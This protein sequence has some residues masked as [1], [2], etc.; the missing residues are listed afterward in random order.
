M[1]STSAVYQNPSRVW[2]VL[3]FLFSVPALSPLF[4]IFPTRSA[5]GLLHLYRLVQLD[6]LWRNGVFFSRWLPDLA[7]GYGLPL[8]NYYAPL[9]YYLTTPF[10]LTGIPFSLALNLSLAASMLGSAMGMFCLTRT[11]LRE[12]PTLEAHTALAA[13]T[14]AIAFL[15][16]PYLLFNPLQ[17]GNLA[18]QWA[19]AFAPFALWRFL[20]LTQKPN[21]LNWVAAAIAFAAV[22]LS[23]NVTSFLFAPLLFVFVLVSVYSNA[24]PSSPPPARAN[25]A[26]ELLRSPVVSISALLLALGLSAFFWLPALLERDLVQIERVIVTPDFDYR[27]NFVPIAELVSFLPHA[28]TGRL[29]PA[30]PSTPGVIQ[31]ALG[32]IGLALLVTRCRVRRALPLFFLAAAALCFTGLML[33]FSQPLWESVSILS[34]VQLPMR[35]RGMVALCLAPIA[36]TAVLV[37]APRW[38]VVGAGIAVTAMIVTAMPVLYPRYAHD[39][40]L[41]PT[42]AEMFAYEHKS[43]VIGTTSFGEYLPVWVQN[44]PDASP[45]EQA[46]AQNRLPDRLVLPEGVISCGGEMH[47]TTQIACVES[48]DSWHALYRGF[49]FPGW[50]AFADQQPVEIEPTPRTGLITFNV[51]KSGQIKVTY[52]GTGIEHV[53]DWIS[54]ASSLIVLGILAFAVVRRA[55]LVCASSI[56]PTE[57]NHSPDS[58]LKI[59]F[60]LFLLALSLLAV[61]FL[62]AD[63]MSNPF[64]AHFDGTQVEGISQPRNV[65]FGNELLLLG[66]DQNA[67]NLRPGEILSTTLYWRALPGLKTN[68]STFVHLTAP[69]GFVL[70]QKDNLHPANL[71]TTQ[72]DLQA[73]AADE[74]S[75][76][77]PSTLAPGEYELRV[78]VYDPRTNTRLDL[79]EG[80]DHFLLGKITVTK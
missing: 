37:L 66:Y 40:P 4:S 27:F 41:S 60:P 55:Q 26:R 52:I 13:F 70:A 35:L 30:F 54:I 19:L 75:F 5:D 42:L 18:E 56:T 17:R 53:G 68:L 15:Y 76:E 43:G 31:L 57:A 11:L 8:F 62:Y 12:I 14:A 45:F 58:P 79:P 47:P 44:P 2:F 6:I 63:R 23:H 80:S 9:A 51:P 50:V 32:L 21:A 65:N 28:D 34:F 71:P 25:S 10:H 61:K 22:M 67:P 39:F 16:S 7:Y 36:G 20:V 64:V 48:S 33:S 74:H 59:L 3:L 69:D 24:S 49:Y 78:G 72:W 38:R 46:Y 77:I 1:V 73:Y 29:N